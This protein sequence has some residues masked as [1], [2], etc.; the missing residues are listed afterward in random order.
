MGRYGPMVQ[1]GDVNDEEKPRFAKLKSGQ[2]IETI[3][4]DEAMELFKLPMTIGEYEGQEV[5]VNI[6]RFGPYVK[7]GEEFVSIPK[8]EDPVTLD[9]DRAVALINEKK[10]A[11]APIATYEGI[12]VTKGKG[13]FGPFIKWNDLYINIPKAYDF[14]RL[15]QKEV[16]ELVSKKIEKEANRYI[17]Q[18]PAEKIS[19]ENGRW[20]PFIRFGKKMLKLSR[21]AD[22]GKYTEEDLA[23]ISIDEV[24]KMIE[25]ELPGAFD[26]KAKAAPAKK[27]ASKKAPKG[28]K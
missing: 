6:G 5:S 27:S 4:Y 3:S 25:A 28:K 13:R 16:N 23:G 20:G 7:W 9:I 10:H 2:S 17:H 19:I 22:G 26:K 12:P 8:G 21:K 15:G 18:W 11:D 14:D 1:I 24:K